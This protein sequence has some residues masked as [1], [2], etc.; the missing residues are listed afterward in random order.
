VKAKIRGLLAEIK[1]LVHRMRIGRK[2]IG[3]RCRA[4]RQTRPKYSYAVAFSHRGR[5]LSRNLL[6]THIGHLAGHG[7]RNRFLEVEEK[8]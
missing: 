3:S 8:K 4:W 1:T 5:G 2:T 7:V 6:M